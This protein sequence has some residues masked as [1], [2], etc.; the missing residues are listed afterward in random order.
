MDPNPEHSERELRRLLLALVGP[1]LLGIV[2]GV[3]IP[4]GP[5]TSLQVL[6]SM[7]LGIAVGWWS[8]FWSR[9]RWA[10]LLAP[11]SFV[12]VFEISRVGLEGPTVDAPVMS[13]YGL[14]ALTVGR[15]FHGLVALAPMVLG[16]ALGAGASRHRARE[17]DE[18]PAQPTTAAKVRRGFAVLWGLGL[19]VL[20]ALVI[21]P[22][23]T[24]PIVDAEGDP[25]EGSIAELTT[26]EAGGRELGLMIRDTS[27]ENPVLLFLAGGPG[28]SERGAMRNHLEELERSF[29]VATWDQ[30]GTG[31]SYD[32]LDPTDT[33]TLEGQVS[34]TIEVTD[35]LR[36]RFDVDRIY[37]LGQSWGPP[38]VCW[39]SRAHPSATRPTS[40]RARWSASSRPTASSTR[41]RCTGP[42][43]M[44]TRAS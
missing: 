5:L 4:R 9:S 30:R 28:G 15:G 44:A 21:R 2:A 29:T 40:A 13:T 23:S 7:I 37:L 42:N 14:L 36:E 18:P 12:V 34:D 38:S 20:A 41:T 11:A 3:W 16:A 22:A 32:Q 43:P 19:L 1:A 27:V 35:H 26:V 8:G 24:A 25:V 33:L 31:T 17:G 39:R 10:M 6:A